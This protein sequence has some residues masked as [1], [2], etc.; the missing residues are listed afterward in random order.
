VSIHPI[1]ELANEKQVKQAKGFT[2]VAVDLKGSE[3]EIKYI[4]EKKNALKRGEA[5]KKYLGV[6]SGR[7]PTGRQNG[8]D[9]AHAS[10]AI[11]AFSKAGGEAPKL[12]DGSELQILDSLVPLRTAT[13]D[14]SKGDADPNKGVD[15]IDVLALLPDNRV[16][17]VCIKYLAADATRGG[18]GDTPLRAVL[19]GLAQ[20]AMI[21]GNQEE[22]REEILEATG[23]TT[24]D[25]CPAVIIAA[26]PRYWELCRRREAQKGALWIRE[27]ERLGREI[28]TEIGVEVFYTALELSGDPQW[29]YNDDG[30][31]L[32]SAAALNLPWESTAGKVKPKPKAK[33]KN[34]TTAEIVEGNM[35]KPCQTYSIRGSFESGDRIDHMTLGQGVVQNSLGR[36]KIKVLFGDDMKALIHE[37]T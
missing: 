23:R 34:S 26:A 8:K 21:D 6:R 30:P 18:A 9:D 27:I 7:I 16:A 4:E 25:E 24:S 28:G 35:D 11:A 3:L 14:S 19:R 20:A 12:P 22:F 13:P 15:D 5:G 36:G 1:I 2:A 32:T 17:V 31:L 33:K 10:M 29:E 37:R